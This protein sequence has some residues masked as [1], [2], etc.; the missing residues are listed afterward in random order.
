MPAVTADSKEF[1]NFL[2]VAQGVV[3]AHLAKIKYP[4]A[5][6]IG[7]EDN[8]KYIRV[9]ITQYSG[10]RSAY[11]FIDKSN[12]DIL[13]AAGWKAPEKKNPRGNI[14]VEGFESCLT[15]C[16]VVYLR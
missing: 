16:G 13:K 7:F 2:T 12:G 14:F 10:S 3:D 6:I 11:C 9:F 5:E 4:W 15:F 1:Q 8:Q